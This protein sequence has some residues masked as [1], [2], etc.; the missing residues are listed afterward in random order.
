MNPRMCL[1]LLPVPPPAR[2]AVLLGTMTVL[3]VGAAAPIALGVTGAAAAS[4]SSRDRDLRGRQARVKGQHQSHP[5][6]KHKQSPTCSGASLAQ[7]TVSPLPGTPEATPQTQIS[8]LGA[9]PSKLSSIYVIGS[10]SGRHTGTLRSYASATGASFLPRVPFL[11]GEHVSVCAT[12]MTESGPHRVASSFEV[13]TAAKL[14]YEAPF[15]IPGTRGEAQTYHS[16]DL[17]PPNVTIVRQPGE[18][19]APGDIFATPYAGPAEHGAMIFESSGRLVWFHRPPNPDWGIADLRLQ[20]F[21]GEEDLVWWQGL[22]NTFGFGDGEDV[23]ANDAY[24]PVARVKGGNGL[25]AD[26][27]DIDLTPSGSAFITAYYPVQVQ[28]AGAKESAGMPRSEVVL[29]SIVQEIDV[30][31]GL[32]MWEWQSLGHV[33][34]AQSHQLPSQHGPYDYFHLDSLQQLPDGDLL[35][36]A[37][38]TWAA[39]DLR[40]HTGNIA[41]Q[42]GGRHSS[43]ALGE[44][45]RF[46]WPQEVTMLPSEQLAVY[47]GG[48]SSSSA[49][50]GE[51]LDLDLASKVA[52][53]ASGGELRR[54]L[55]SPRS[56]GEGSMQA[57]PGG[58]WLLGWAGLP[59]FTEYDGEGNVLYDARFPA[60]EVGYR[61]YREPWHGQPTTQP[62]VV[63]SANANATTVYA[64]WNGA[65]E[66]AAWMLLAGASPLALEPVA[67]VPCSGFETTISTT[68][69]AAYV[70]VQALNAAGEVLT[71]SK[72]I[73]AAHS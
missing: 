46:A 34:L 37:R 62:N 30:H 24:E 53:L 63:T 50:R 3:L 47:D 36:G 13:A 26:L 29:D 71:E 64:S 1:G 4:A 9:A 18:A 73:A 68:Q 32:V 59:N 40:L 72:A 57:L 35:I 67:T 55:P 11:E 5:H 65:T 39:Y 48:V 28:V 70:E 15:E 56:P 69:P 14:H 60:S 41:W 8:F 42:L 20:S 54:P 45:A 7:V 61:V 52:S 19:S 33:P 10:R 17:K 31:T 25:Q 21:E 16:V 49:P 51:V 38:N 23:I 27:H 58:N 22:I 12:V 2:L 6:Q 44:G 66:V 43:F